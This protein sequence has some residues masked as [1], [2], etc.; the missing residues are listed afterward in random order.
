[1]KEDKGR[2]KPDDKTEQ[3]IS[4]LPGMRMRTRQDDIGTLCEN[5]IQLRV[6]SGERGKESVRVLSKRSDDATAGSYAD[7]GLQSEVSHNKS[8]ATQAIGHRNVNEDRGRHSLSHG[9]DKKMKTIAEGYVKEFS[10]PIQNSQL[11][12]ARSDSSFYDHTRESGICGS[13]RTTDL[14]WLEKIE[15]IEGWMKLYESEFS[16]ERQKEIG[17]KIN[18]TEVKDNANLVMQEA[19]NVASHPPLTKGTT[20]SMETSNVQKSTAFLPNYVDVIGAKHRES[21]TQRTSECSGRHPR[22][23]RENNSSSIKRSQQDLHSLKYISAETL[24]ETEFKQQNFRTRDKESFI[25]NTLT[26]IYEETGQPLNTERTQEGFFGP[27]TST[28]TENRFLENISL[29]PSSNSQNTNYSSRTNNFKEDEIVVEPM[30]QAVRIEQQE[31]QQFMARSQFK[32]P[33]TGRGKSATLEQI[34][35]MIEPKIEEAAVNECKSRNTEATTELSKRSSFY[36]LIPDIVQVKAGID[37][38]SKILDKLDEMMK[39]SGIVDRSKCKTKDTKTAS[40]QG[41]EILMTG[42]DESSAIGKAE[43]I[44]CDPLSFLPDTSH[45]KLRSDPKNSKISDKSQNV[46]GACHELSVFKQMSGGRI[47]ECTPEVSLQCP[48]LQKFPAEQS[49]VLGCRTTYCCPVGEYQT[50]V[51]QSLSLISISFKTYSLV[52]S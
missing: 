6:E 28:N 41:S 48:S 23:E 11:T 27:V 35:A 25:P 5:R 7:E 12:S 31:N 37:N 40:V 22:T 45:S 47:I 50:S 13:D 34:E 44:S 49:G 42:D 24:E 33:S 21:L 52:H 30:C 14:K 3:T 43:I 17:N 18:N 19:H 29:P 51:R 8:Q 10:P 2:E 46:S 9:E 36:S 1:V 20:R 38:Q 26:K 32:K 39:H 16:N 15:A 4:K